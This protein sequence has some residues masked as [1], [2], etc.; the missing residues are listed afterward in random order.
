MPKLSLLLLF[1]LLAAAQLTPNSVTVTATRSAS[2]P[3]DVVHFNVSVDAGIDATKEAVLAAVSG[4]GL[5]ATNFTGVSGYS[6]DSDRRPVTWNFTLT[7]PLSNLRSTIALLTAVKN[8]MAK[9]NRFGLSFSI[10][11]SDASPQATGCPVAD[12]IADARSQAS[13]LAVGAGL[14]V[15]AIQAISTATDSIPASGFGGI[16]GTAAASSPVCSITVKFALGGL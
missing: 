11:G 7:A 13:K 8:S 10:Q 15:G 14:S 16:G 3:P 12:L 5:T 9:D 6:L 4:A 2:P 1:P